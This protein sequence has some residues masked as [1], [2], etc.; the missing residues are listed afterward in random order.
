MVRVLQ[1]SSTVTGLVISSNLEPIFLLAGLV[2]HVSESIPRLRIYRR[3]NSEFLTANLWLIHVEAMDIAGSVI[4]LDI[5]FC[6]GHIL[7]KSFAQSSSSS[8]ESSTSEEWELRNRNLEQ[9]FWIKLHIT[10]WS[11]TQSMI[12]FISR[13]LKKSLTENQNSSSWCR[14]PD[15]FQR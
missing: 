9:I 8:F 15:S 11:V 6:I 1:T 13:L 7:R 10:S 5:D 2:L 14:P 3:I 4:A 12:I